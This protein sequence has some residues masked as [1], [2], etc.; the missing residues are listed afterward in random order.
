[1]GM[2]GHRDSLCWWRGAKLRA[3]RRSVSAVSAIDVQD[4][5]RDKSGIVRR[6]E[7]DAVGDFLRETE[8]AQRNLRRQGRLVLC[9]AGEARQHAGVGGARC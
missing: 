8:T 9:R 3:R 2:S 4:M 7:H 5:A 1:M 6:N